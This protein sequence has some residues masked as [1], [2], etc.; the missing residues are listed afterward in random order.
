[1][2]RRSRSGPILVTMATVGLLVA[3]CD[4]G[5]VSFGSPGTSAGHGRSATSEPPVCYPQCP[6]RPPPAVHRSDTPDWAALSTWL[7]GQAVAREFSGAV[8]VDRHGSPIVRQAAGFADIERHSVNR[9]DTKFNIG[10]VGK[11]FTAVAIAQLAEQ[12]K[13]SFDEPVSTYLTGFSAGTGSQIT[14]S[15]LLTH[16]S[17]L[18]DVFARWHP[19]GPHPL[20]VPHIMTRITSEPAQF[21][22]GSRF[23]YSNSGYVV[24]GAIIEAVTGHSYYDY[25]REH[26]LIP[27]GMTH[28]D[29]YAPG[30]VANMARGH[31]PVRQPGN[32]PSLRDAGGAG[33]PGNPSGGAYSTVDDLARFAQALLRHKLLSAAMTGTLLTGRVDTQ[34]PGAPQISQ[35]GYGFEDEVLNGVPI[36]GHGGGAP[37]IEAQLRIY[38]TL[39]Y[40]VVILANQDRAAT[41]VYDRVNQTLGLVGQ[42]R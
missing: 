42:T 17:G 36:V 20:P 38:P 21:P 41:P 26:I 34:R 37:G 11:V 30:Q 25:L 35:Y 2:H 6:R 7:A 29:W 27:A 14:V 16:T 31:M 5:S 8:L 22:P 24:L 9:L 33:P 40:I 18:G 1:M 19:T 13:V 12:G 10:S 28:T 23:S 32:P 3:G 4:V 15:Q 39:G